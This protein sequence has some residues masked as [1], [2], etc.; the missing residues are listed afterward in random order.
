VAPAT[1]P[2]PTVGDAPLSVAVGDVDKDGDLDLLVANYT[3]NGTVS[4][5]LNDGQGGFSAPATNPNPAVGDHPL[6]VALGD[7]DGDGDLDLLAANNSANTVSVRLND[8]RGNF[9]APATNPNPAVGNLPTSVVLGDVDKDGDLDLLVANDLSGTVSVRL[10]DGHG[11]FSAPA[12][13]PNPA[14][15]ERPLSVVVGDV[16]G[17]GDLDLLTANSFGHSVS[18]RLN[19]GQGSFSAPATNPN[20]AVGNLPFNVVLGDVDKDGDLDLLV[21]NAGDGTVSM[22]LNN[23]Q[24]NFTMPATNPDLVV[25]N[26]P[27]SVTLGDVDGDGDLDLLTANSSANTVSVRLNNGQGNFTAP[28][29]NPNPAV[30]NDPRSVVVGDLDGDGDL[31]LLTANFKNNTVSVRLNQPV[32]L[33]PVRPS[34][35]TSALTLFPN[36]T[37]GSPTL[38]GAAPGTPVE[39]VDALGRAVLRTSADAA[40]TA[41]LVLPP[42]LPRGVYLVRTNQQILRVALE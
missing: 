25:G 7:V 11:S 16:D 6:S 12:T 21:A 42:G 17:D 20:P 28:A 5:R 9:T 39:V 29:T 10:N 31:D 36:P 4:V 35:L 34:A 23:G 2:D 37:H 18:V 26:D 27:R 1:N 3:S 30:G 19:D 8:G 33:L 22:R 13:N 40:G 41:T 14:V 38:H 15:G 24:G 32:G